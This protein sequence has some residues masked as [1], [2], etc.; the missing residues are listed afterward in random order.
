MGAFAVVLALLPLAARSQNYYYKPYPDPQARIARSDP[1]A[2]PAYAPAAP[3]YAPGPYLPP[4]YDFAWDVLDTYSGNDFGHKESRNDK[5]TT[6]SYHVALPDGRVQTVTYTVDG[7]G[8]YAAEVTYAGEAAYP[9]TPAYKPAPAYVPAPSYP[10]PTYA[11]APVVVKAAPVE[12]AQPAVKVSE[13]VPA[14]TYAP[15]THAPVVY[16]PA[17]A[18]KPAPVPAPGYTARRYSYKVVEPEAP[19]AEESRSV[20]GRPVANIIQASAEKEVE[21]EQELAAAITEIEA[22]DSAQSVELVEEEEEEPV[23]VT[24]ATPASYYYRFY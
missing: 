4:I 14:P 3:A 2:P 17:P 20:A 21:E 19:A 8:G 22:N 23:A 16:K 11:A 15:V 12:P 18:Y 10:K 5:L 24:Q 7:Y 6:G 9:D 13:P 1:P